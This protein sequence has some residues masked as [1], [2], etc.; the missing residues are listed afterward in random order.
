MALCWGHFLTRA[1]I[2]LHSHT[3]TPPIPTDRSFLLVHGRS[4]GTLLEK[5]HF[6]PRPHQQ[7]RHRTQRTIL[8]RT[9][10]VPR[11]IAHRRTLIRS[12]G[13]RRHPNSNSN[14]NS[15]SKCKASSPRAYQQCTNFCMY[16]S[17]TAAGEGGAKGRGEG[18]VEVEVEGGG[19]RGSQRPLA[20]L[21]ACGT[22]R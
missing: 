12:C 18:E 2:C 8:D 22:A 14:S 3:R 6:A 15:N 20:S 7:P 13:V 9:R 10:S 5:R 17:A 11:P 21:L 4:S 19:D 16:G 1:H